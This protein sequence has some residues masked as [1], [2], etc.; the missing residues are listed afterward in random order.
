MDCFFSLSLSSVY[1]E[2]SFCLSE[3]DDEK[4]SPIYEWTQYATKVFLKMWCQI[5]FLGDD[6]GLGLNC[7]T[8]HSQEC[9][10]A[11]VLNLPVDKYN[12]MKD[13]KME[14]SLI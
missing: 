1:L 7:C 13:F 5:D 6:V 12:K 9:A 11:F 14:K 2:F 8:F 3:E 4:K 10:I